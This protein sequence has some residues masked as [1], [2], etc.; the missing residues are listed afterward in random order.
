MYQNRKDKNGDYVRNIDGTIKYFPQFDR[1]VD[2]VWKIS[3]LNP[4]VKERV[5][6]DTQKPKALLKRIIEI[7]TNKGDLVADFFLRKWHFYGCG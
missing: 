7:S 3:I 1:Y 2:D 5:G 6:Y 4:R